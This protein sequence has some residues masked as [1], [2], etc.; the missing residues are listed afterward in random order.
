MSSRDVRKVSFA[1]TFIF[2]ASFA[3]EKLSLL[4]Q[5]PF[6]V[7]VGGN[8]ENIPVQPYS[9]QCLHQSTSHNVWCS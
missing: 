1:P 6:A 4:S 5:F 8:F 7:G 9:L 2:Y 3:F